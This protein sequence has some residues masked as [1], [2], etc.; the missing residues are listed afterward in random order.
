MSKTR[1]INPWTWQD[2]YGFSQAVESSGATRLLVCSGQTSV[3]ADGHPLHAG[4]MAAQL[5]QALDNLEAVLRAA[6]LGFADVVR[7]NYYTT[8]VPAYLAASGEVAKRFANNS[9]CP[10]A[11]TLLGVASLFHPDLMIEIEATALA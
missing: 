7:L 9:R 1:A 2:A 3:D 10:P 11:G 6:G 5:S 4:D 8:D